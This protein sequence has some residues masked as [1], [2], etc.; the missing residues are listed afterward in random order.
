MKDNSSVT[1]KMVNRN[2]VLKRKRKKLPYGP[3]TS[4]SKKNNSAPSESPG[5][6]SSNH[7][8]KSKITS[9]RFSRKK[10]GNDGVIYLL[11]YSPSCS[12]YFVS[13]S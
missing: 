12:L 9:A 8:L 10:K 11:V 4:K 7:E 5:N 2:W 13:P 3:D 1:S 6:V